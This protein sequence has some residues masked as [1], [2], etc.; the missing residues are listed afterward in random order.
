MR[1]SYCAWHQS[2]ID[3]CIEQNEVCENAFNVLESAKH[4]KKFSAAF[5]KTAIGENSSIQKCAPGR[6]L[7]SHG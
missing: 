5:C 1:H 4:I 6:K 7:L 2:L 3:A